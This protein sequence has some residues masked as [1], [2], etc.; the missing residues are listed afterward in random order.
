MNCRD[1]Q[2]WLLEAEDPRPQWCSLPAAADHLEACDACQRFANRLAQL[3]QTWQ[4]LPAPPQ[5]DRAKAA[6]LQRLAEPAVPA[7]PTIQRAT[8]VSRRHVLRWCAASA[9]SLLATGAGG[10]LF[11]SQQEARGAEDLL[12]RLVDW[13]IRITD[14]SSEAQRSQLYAEQAGQLRRAL[15]GANLPPEQAKLAA[16]FFENGAWLVSHRDPIVEAGRFDGLADRLLQLAR[17]AGAGSN[18]KRMHR[19][20][21]QYNRVLESGI[22]VNVDRA[23]ASGTLDFEHQRKLE[24]LALGDGERM[25]QLAALL[26]GA[27][28]SS[29]KDIQRALGIHGTHAKKYRAKRP[30]HTGKAKEKHETDAG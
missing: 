12:D 23:E 8:P 1:V 25:Q 10:W 15:D 22:E 2:E 16:D 30:S 29:R 4:S 7:A 17:A 14:A 3:E 18:P 21:A 20:L 13:N 6:F 26:N 11:L 24:R 5:A 27:P 9:A 19:L 28:D